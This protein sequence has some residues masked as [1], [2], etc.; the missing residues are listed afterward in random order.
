MAEL[1]SETGLATELTTVPAWS[2]EGSGIVRTFTFSSYME[3][4]RFVQRVAE[5]AEARN[6]HPDIHIG[7]RKVTL[8]LTTHSKGG[9]TSL[10]FEL[11]R[12]VDGL[13]A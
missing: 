8:Q 12:A 7:W 2:R 13:T 6:H 11:A 9:L 4:I 1:L 3:G 5:L 10:D